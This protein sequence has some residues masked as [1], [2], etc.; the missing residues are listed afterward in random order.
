VRVYI[1]K[2]KQAID[3]QLQEITALGQEEFE[4]LLKDA[5]AKWKAF[6][7]TVCTE[8][9]KNK[10][11]NPRTGKK[12]SEKGKVWKQLHYTCP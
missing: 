10:S 7:E 5:E 1:R 9:N 4:G 6:T 12:I 3:S 2:Y 8:W 11:I